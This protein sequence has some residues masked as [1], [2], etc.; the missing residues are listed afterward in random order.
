MQIHL[1]ERNGGRTNVYRGLP[2]GTF[3]LLGYMTDKQTIVDDDCNPMKYDESLAKI[4]SAFY[5]AACYTFRY[6]SIT[7]K[8]ESPGHGEALLPDYLMLE[9]Q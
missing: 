5:F 2:G 9:K 3:H 1:R 6:T 7:K 8:N 4:Q